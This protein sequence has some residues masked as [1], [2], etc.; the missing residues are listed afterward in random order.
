[1]CTGLQRKRALVQLRVTGGSV[2]TSSS[3]TWIRF[4]NSNTGFRT[5][6][7]HPHGSK[8]R[9]DR[10]SSLTAQ[11]YS[12]LLSIPLIPAVVG[13]DLFDFTVSDTFVRSYFGSSHN[14]HSNGDVHILA[15]CSLFHYWI[16]WD[17]RTNGSCYSTSPRLGVKM[18]FLEKK[19]GIRL[20]ARY[21]LRV[22]P[23]PII[24]R[25]R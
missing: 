23:T 25:Q 17:C 6:K 1:M 12:N 9:G 4:G 18:F 24:L 3:R 19:T 7:L 16:I 8:N 20:E 11:V 2:R 5:R 13:F 14:L 10:G 15:F 22:V 21:L